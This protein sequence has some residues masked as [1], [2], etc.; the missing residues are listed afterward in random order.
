MKNFWLEDN[1]NIYIDMMRMRSKTLKISF[2]SFVN[3]FETRK[4]KEQEN[5]IYRNDKI[6]ITK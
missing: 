3:Q 5:V 1:L 4:K 6:M 2:N